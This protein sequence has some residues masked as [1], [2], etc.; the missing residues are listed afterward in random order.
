MIRPIILETRRSQSTA[1]GYLEELPFLDRT[2]DQ[3]DDN[4]PRNISA[5][6]AKATAAK[7][8]RL[9]SKKNRGSK[10]VLARV[11]PVV[12]LA[13]RPGCLKNVKSSATSMIK[14]SHVLTSPSRLLLANTVPNSENGDVLQNGTTPFS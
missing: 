12:A 2:S 1:K 3:W 13:V 11:V 7:N 8:G 4:F 6:C 5:E 14:D 9:E 10:H